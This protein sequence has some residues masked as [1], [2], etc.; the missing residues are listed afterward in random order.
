MLKADPYITFHS[1]KIVQTGPDTLVLPGAF[2]ILVTRAFS[3][4]LFTS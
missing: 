2:T 1:D 3:V 4:P